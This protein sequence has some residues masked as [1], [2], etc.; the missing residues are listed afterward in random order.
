MK[1]GVRNLNHSSHQSQDNCP[2]KKA[3]HKG[4]EISLETLEI[5]LTSVPEEEIRLTET[6]TAD[7][8]DNKTRYLKNIRKALLHKKHYIKRLQHLKQRKRGA[9]WLHQNLSYFQSKFPWE[10]V[11]LLENMAHKQTPG[12]KCKTLKAINDIKNHEETTPIVTD[13]CPVEGLEIFT[14]NIRRLIFNSLESPL[15][16][17]TETLITNSNEADLQVLNDW[18]IN[19]ETHF[20]KVEELIFEGQNFFSLRNFRHIQNLPLSEQTR[21]AVN[22]C[23]ERYDTSSVPL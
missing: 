9:E 11:S 17:L 23:I 14:T 4:A 18:C 6:E 3:P 1:T 16:Q 13:N 10:L 7:L 19:I 20:Q 21:S 15:A 5:L 12:I 2:P 8:Q 22:A